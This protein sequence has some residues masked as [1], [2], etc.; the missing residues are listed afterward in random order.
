[1]NIAGEDGAGEE[2]EE[3]E[4]DVGKEEDGVTREATEGEADGVEIAEEELEE[5]LS[6]RFTGAA[7]GLLPAAATGVAD[8]AA[9]DA[10]VAPCLASR[11]C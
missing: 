10:A 1:M 5:L 8:E 9:A 7:T 4:E 2:I 11:C 6:D 3:E